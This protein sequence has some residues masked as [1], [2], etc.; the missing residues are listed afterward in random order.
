MVIFD[1]MYKYTVCVSLRYTNFGIQENALK[2]VYIGALVKMGIGKI[3][4]YKK[5]NVKQEYKQNI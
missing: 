3:I 5:I 1:M 4:S 2:R